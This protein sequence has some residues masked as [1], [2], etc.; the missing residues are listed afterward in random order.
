[1]TASRE[2]CEHVSDLLQGFGPLSIRRMFGGAGVFRD[3]LMFALIADDTLYMKVDG[4]TRPTYEALGM[5]PFTYQRAGEVAALGF[6]QAPESAM[7]DAEELRDLAREAFAVALR[8]QA[9]KAMKKP[10][11]KS[12]TKRR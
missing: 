7:E 10:A 12:K 1:M 9:G 4:T 3:G 11:P 6:Y 2:F 8:A 5:G